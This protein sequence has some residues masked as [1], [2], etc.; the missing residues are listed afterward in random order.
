MKGVR[1]VL[2]SRDTDAYVFAVVIGIENLSVDFHRVPNR[3]ETILGQ[4]Q[5]VVL[6]AFR[7]I[8]P[9]RPD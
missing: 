9:F 7:S 4:Q 1:R 8:G 2:S 6:A 5:Q 3:R